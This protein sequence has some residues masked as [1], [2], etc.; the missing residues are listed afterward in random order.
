MEIHNLTAHD[1][2]SMD[3]KSLIALGL[4]IY[5]QTR[6][7]QLNNENRTIDRL[8]RD[9]QL[10]HDLMSNIFDNDDETPRLCRTTKGYRTN[11]GFTQ[12]V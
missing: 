12:E 8:K 6:G 4:K 3:A 1:K 11:R 9:I 2:P 7:T 5:I 10:K